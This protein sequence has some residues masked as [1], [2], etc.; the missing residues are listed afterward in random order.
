VVWRLSREGV[1]YE[2][3]AV[4]PMELAQLI[5][6]F[7]TDL[8][9]GAWTNATK[10][11]AKRLY[12][13][14]LGSARLSSGPLVIVPDGVLHE[15][16]FG[17]T[18]DPQNG[19]FLVEEREVTV[20]TSAGAFLRG[21]ERWQRQPHRPA[22][23]LVIGDPKVDAALF[24]DI[25]ALAGA[26]NEAREVAAL[27][28]HRELLLGGAATREAFLNGVSR[29]RVIHFAGH[30]MINRVDP[31]RTS[32]PLASGPNGSQGLLTAADI[33]RLDL[34]G[35]NTVV[36]SGCETGV[37]EDGEG[38]APLS[39]AHAFLVA[40]T[41]TVVA[42]LWPIAD[43]PSA[44]LMTA[45][46]RRLLR[47]ERPASALRGAQLEMLRSSEPILR[48]PGVWAAFAAIGG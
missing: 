6:A 30:A 25:R 36:L 47:G 42:S 5:S 19:R 45:F 23:A 41:P 31:A 46:H 11:T 21:R 22:D 37:G 38:E 29:R 14:L 27:Y 35:T 13:A 16:P 9:V 10:A 43:A 26:R 24:P 40:G 2:R 3:L 4:E 17:A 8:K 1:S 32:L 34:S 44:P 7:G 15:L 12:F 33:A 28:P 39:L 18:I 20:A 48:S